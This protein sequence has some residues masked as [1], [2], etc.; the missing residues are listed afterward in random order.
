MTVNKTISQCAA[1]T[2]LR[3]PS[4]TEVDST[5]PR[6]TDSVMDTEVRSSGDGIADM[7]RQLSLLPDDPGANGKG[8]GLGIG[9]RPAAGGGYQ[10]NCNVFEFSANPKKSTAT[11]A[12]LSLRRWDCRI[13]GSRSRITSGSMPFWNVAD[14][15]CK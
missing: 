14:I 10:D 15:G 3:H 1:S 7:P 13:T 6:A 4:E 9:H 12:W 11:R 5:T 8:V 2:E